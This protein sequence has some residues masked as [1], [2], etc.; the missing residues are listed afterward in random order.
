MIF[1]YSFNAEEYLQLKQKRTKLRRTKQYLKRS[2]RLKLKDYS[3]QIFNY[4]LYQRRY[5][6]LAVIEN[7]LQN[8]IDNDDFY[9]YYVGLTYE[10]QRMI[11]FKLSL[12]ELKEVRN[13]PE[14]EP[15]SI[16]I[17]NVNV[18]CDL[19]DVD[20]FPDDENNYLKDLV[21]DEYTLYLKSDLAIDVNIEL[22]LVQL[23]EASNPLLMDLSPSF[24]ESKNNLVFQESLEAKTENY[25]DSKVLREAM[26]FFLLLT[27]IVY[28]YLKT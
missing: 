24:I 27:S 12:E 13:Y 23:E 15:L 5:I 4:C 14:S 9:N 17:S 7:F 19:Y 3:D 16:L 25:N 26:I 18:Y 10:L 8:K 1:K 21:Q 2:E 11:Q 28:Y 20:G 22:D 6:F